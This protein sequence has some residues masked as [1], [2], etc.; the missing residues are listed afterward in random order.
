[1]TARKKPIANKT[2]AQKM[3]AK[4][5]AA[6]EGGS[7]SSPRRSSVAPRASEAHLAE[8]CP[9]CGSPTFAPEERT[10]F[11]GRRIVRTTVLVCERGHTFAKP[12]K[13]PR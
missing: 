11:E 13:A 6:K 5:I 7:E 2:T 1:V 3:V 8:V 10:R 4:R 12:A 9:R